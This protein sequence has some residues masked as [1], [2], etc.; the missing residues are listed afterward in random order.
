MTFPLLCPRLKLGQTEVS[1]DESAVGH[2][3]FMISLDDQVYGPFE[4][5]RMS[6]SRA[7]GGKTSLPLAS[8]FPC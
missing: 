3:G 2:T 8:F 6:P 4:K 1:V 7:F 5:V